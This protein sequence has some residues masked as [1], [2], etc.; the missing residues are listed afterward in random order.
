MENV[1]LS[2]PWEI[3]WKKMTALFGEDPDIEKWGSVSDTDI[4]DMPKEIYDKAVELS[5]KEDLA[6]KLIVVRV[7][8]C[9]TSYLDSQK[10]RSV[11][12]LFN[13]TIK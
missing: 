4:G 9:G 13:K 2:A 6:A 12:Y 8:Y 1:K 5:A 7:L 3:L 10:E 11:V